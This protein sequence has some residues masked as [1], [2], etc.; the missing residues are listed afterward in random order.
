MSSS[1]TLRVLA[2]VLVLS[3]AAAGYAQCQLDSYDFEEAECID[4][5]CTPAT[6]LATPGTCTVLTLVVP[7]GSIEILA[8]FGYDGCG[9]ASEDYA[10]DNAAPGTNTTTCRFVE[11]SADTICFFPVCYAFGAPT[12]ECL[13]TLDCSEG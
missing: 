2:G 10:C 11:W 9:P 3:I 4:K 7:F 5:S 12:D 13:G 6:C 1:V 8:P